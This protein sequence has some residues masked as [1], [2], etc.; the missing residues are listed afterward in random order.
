[1]AIYLFFAGEVPMS[2]QPVVADAVTGALELA[3]E[4]RRLIDAAADL[5]DNDDFGARR[6]ATA[7]YVEARP[8][9]WTTASY[10]AQR[11]ADLQLSANQMRI[12]SAL[13]I[14]LRPGDDFLRA[15]DTLVPLN[16]PAAAALSAAYADYG[17][18][19]SE[20]ELLAR[21]VR[22]MPPTEL[23]GR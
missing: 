7:C 5:Y 20:E 15:L 9:Y 13:K 8:A 21:R 11:H 17:S 10:H 1:V 18:F 2:I 6:I 4:A 23:C 16:E 22:R 12:A 14:S 3:H 19:V